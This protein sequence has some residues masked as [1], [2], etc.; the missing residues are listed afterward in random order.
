VPASSHVNGAAVFKRVCAACHVSIVQASAAGSAKSLDSRAMPQELLKSFPPNAILNALT[1][2]KM[3]AQGSA[4]NEGEKRAVAE[5]VSG[6]TFEQAKASSTEKPNPCTDG[7]TM[8]DPA[9]GPAWNGWGNGPA[10][11]RFQDKAQGGLTAA[12]LPRLELKWAYGYPNVSTTRAQPSVAGGR[13]FIASENGEVRALNA[14]TGCTY[15]IFKAQAGVTSSP[16]VGAYRSA[17]GQSGFAVYFGDRKANAYAVDAQTGRAVWTRRVDAHK[18][19]GITG[20]FTYFGGR[21]FVP[22]QGIAEESLGSHNDYPCCTFR[23]SVSAL[24][25]S[26]GAVVWKTYTVGESHPRGKTKSGIESFGPAGG[27][28]WSAPTVDAKRHLVYVGTG[29]GFADPP[30][31]MTDAVIALDLE[32]G[33]VKW[34]HQAKAGD[35]W[36]MGCDATNPGNPVC[37]Q[38]LGPDYDFSAPP[39][40]AHLAGRDL[41]VLPQKAAIAWALDPDTGS[42]VWKFAFGQ[43]SGLG[44]QWGTAIEGGRAYFGVADMLTPHPGGVQAITLATGKP[45]WRMP[46]QPKLCGEAIGCNAGQGGPLTAIPGAVLSAAMDGGL[47]AYSIK[48]GSIL[49]TFNAN[50]AFDT[51]N[52]LKAHGGSMDNAG[53]VVAGGML[54]VN[55]GYGGLLGIA[56]NVLLAFGPRER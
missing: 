20:S 2:G 45:A 17:A 38:S 32:T 8:R 31:P 14:K 41:V 46:P 9:S 11:T 29:N 39:A 23:G 33:A 25:A 26:T 4:L 6:K 27:S 30:Q 48:D 36:A 12:D 16:V 28:I 13:L 43:G 42:V 18:L 22:V 7:L 50:R 24:D 55:S 19:A 56:G 47:R 35:N 21:I 5:F 10:N 51:V 53:P 3:Q 44:G 1:T 34:A 52:G 37:P 40:L 49:W 15:W 54:Y